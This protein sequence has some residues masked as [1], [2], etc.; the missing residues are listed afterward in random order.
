MKKTLFALCALF[1]SIFTITSCDPA[2]STSEGS[3][4]GIYTVD[5]SFLRPELNDTAYFSVSEAR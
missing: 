4:Q 3:F 2:T 5:R 1:V